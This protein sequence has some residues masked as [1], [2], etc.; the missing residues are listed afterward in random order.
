MSRVL[1][2]GRFDAVF[3]VAYDWVNGT[4][5]AQVEAAARSCGSALQRYVFMVPGAAVDYPFED[6]LLAATT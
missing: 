6:R 5:A 1:G 4:P 3:D 2:N